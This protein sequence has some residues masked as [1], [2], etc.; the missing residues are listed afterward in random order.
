M[1]I[2][3]LQAR[4]SSQRL[5]G[6]VLKH[7][8]GVPML[9][10]HLERLARCRSL[11][12]LIVATSTDASDDPLVAWCQNEGHTVYRGPLEDVLTRYMHAAE[13]H[14][15]SWVIR[16]TGDCPLADPGLIDRTVD[17]AVHANRDYFSNIEP[18]TWPVGMDVEVIRMDALRSAFREA[19][20]PSDREHVTPFLRRQPER[21]SHGVLRAPR[22]LSGLRLTVDEPQDFELVCRIYAALLPE[23]PTFDLN[24]ILNL[25]E[26]HPDW[27]ALNGGIL[28]H[29]GCRPSLSRES[30]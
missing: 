2:A 27:L 3:L 18:R 28:H 4:M 25:L 29:E 5:P 12:R 1:K 30:T 14:A 22:D 15:A 20:R 10:R 19:T 26:A 8:L 6:K 24:D 21:F 16:L 13:A 23:R 11:D 9:G 7:I 17:G